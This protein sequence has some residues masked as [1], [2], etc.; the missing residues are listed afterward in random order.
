[1]FPPRLSHRRAACARWRDSDIGHC[2]S[3]QWRSRTVRLANGQVTAYVA[4]WHFEASRGSGIL[5]PQRFLAQ[6]L[7]TEP[8][9]L[10]ER[11]ARDNEIDAPFIAPSELIDTDCLFPSVVT[12]SL[13]LNAAALTITSN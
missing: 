6:I 8:A 5:G 11:Y 10:S 12:E 9:S 4:P 2:S 7:G 1:M 3:G 13:A